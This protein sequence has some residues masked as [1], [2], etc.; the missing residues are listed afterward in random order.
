MRNFNIEDFR[1]AGQYL[2]RADNDNF[3]SNTG[4]LS[5]VLKKVGWITPNHHTF[6]DVPEKGNIYTLTDLSDGMTSCGYFDQRDDLES[7]KNPRIITSE[8]IAKW[9]W[10]QFNGVQSLC[11]YLNNP[12]LSQEHRFATHEEIVRVALY[13]KHRCK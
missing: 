10:V 13:Q 6:V 1:G 12:D 2:I 3:I 8:G 4:Y 11:D 9:K 7:K 5:T